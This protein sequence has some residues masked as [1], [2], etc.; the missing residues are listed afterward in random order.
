MKTIKILLLLLA[1]TS[2]GSCKKYL[3]AKPDQALATP[4][5]LQDLQELLDYYGLNT[6][7]PNGT[8]ILADNYY[9]TF[10]NWSS[11]FR[12]NQRDYYIWKPN[13]NN[14]LEWNQPYT[15]IY[16]C[17]L[18]LETLK[19]ISYAESD[20]PV[21]DHI[22]GTALFLRGSYFYSLAQLFA[23]AYDK[24]TATTDPG[25]PLR[26][27]TD[28]TQKSTRASLEE[29]YRQ[30]IKDFKQAVSLVPVNVSIKT[31]PSKAAAY[32]ALARTYLAMQDYSN[33]ALYA[34]S[35]LDLYNTLIDYNSLNSTAPIPFSR[36]NDEVIFHATAYAVQ[37]LAPKICKI[38]SNLYNSYDTND[39]RKVIFFKSNG[40]GTYGFKGDYDGS[41]N[42]GNG[43][44][45]TGIVTDEQYLILA[46]CDARLGKTSDALHYLNALLE[47][48]WRSGEFIA[49]TVTDHTALLTLILKERR[50]E[51]LFRA[52]RLTDLKRL[53]KD[54]NY[55]VTVYRNLNGTVYILPPNDNRYVA[56]IPKTVIGISG[57]QQNP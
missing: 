22:Q 6:Q 44:S 30:I 5:T 29:T 25:I 27:S 33:A 42:N 4:S 52:L 31:K 1:V 46:E 23:K 2:L 57:M 28:V 17:N 26:L 16:T 47:K 53:N 7:F 9:L 40:N 14:D 19:K 51:L 20:Q 24:T 35:C 10:P 50:K 34:D 13:S 36:F 11:I 55:Q 8:E 15:N 39:L 43:H 45:F 21:A 3:D 32:G 56:L 41:S 49:V 54:L 48:R 18:V 37:P 38:D 12:V